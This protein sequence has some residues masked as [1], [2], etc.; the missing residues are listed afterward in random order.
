MDKRSLQRLFDYHYWA[1]RR[2][3]RSVAP[4]S[5]EQFTQKLSDG[6]LSIRSQIV[7]MVSNENLWV[8]YLWHGEVEFLR[9]CHLPTRD[10][11][12]LE[13]D[14]LEEEIRDFID[15]LSLADLERQVEPPF[16]DSG[17]SLS[18]WESLLQVVTHAAEGRAR[19]C[20][21]L[22]Q[23]GSSRIALDYFDFLAEQ[24]RSAPVFGMKLR[25][26]RAWT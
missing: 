13:W 8:N 7:D 16:L 17:L 18:V 21:H 25:E 15:E 22:Q 1:N 24:R 6:T 12:R 14:A 23:F 3:W 10:H 5:D 26:A 2:L 4:L 11:I 9:D 20:L 19:T